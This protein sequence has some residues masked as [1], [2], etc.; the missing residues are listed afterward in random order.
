MSATPENHTASSASPIRGYGRARSALE[1][2][3]NLAC[4][5]QQR[6]YQASQYPESPHYQPLS[7]ETTP[8][9]TASLALSTRSNGPTALPITRL[10]SS[11]DRNASPTVGRRSSISSGL[12][13]HSMEPSQ[14]MSSLHNYRTDQLVDRYIADSPKIGSPVPATRSVTSDALPP[15]RP[16]PEQSQVPTP[17]DV[18][19]ESVKIGSAA[20]SEARENR[21]NI[22]SL[23]ERTFSQMAQQLLMA[24]LPALGWR[25]I[26]SLRLTSRALKSVIDTDGREL[27]LERFLGPQGYRIY[28][29]VQSQVRSLVPDDEIVTLDLRDLGAFRASQVVPLEQYSRFAKACGAGRLST[30]DLRLA[31]ATTRAWNRV[32]LRLRAQSLLPPASF[33]VPSFPDFVSDDQPVYKP[34]RAPQLRVWVPTNRGESWMTDGELIECEREIWRSGKGVWSQLRKGDIVTNIAI[35][36]FGNLGRMIYD[37]KFLRDLSFEWDVVG[38]LPNWLN[39]LAFSPS[40]FHGI[41][42]S[43]SSNPVFYLCLAPFVQQLQQTLRLESEKVSLASPQGHYQVKRHV[44]RGNIELSGGRILETAGGTTG[45]YEV[46][47]PDWDGTLHLETE[48]TTEHASLLI[49][50]TASNMPTP[51]HIVREKSRLGHLWIRPVAQK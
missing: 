8:P 42:A 17:V 41:L 40:H 39:M 26:V 29:P 32:V 22:Q 3:L 9:R 21:A 33:S 23:F 45:G 5:A 14:P 12:V 43:S 25:D 38:H 51:W 18:S 34:P 1:E 16:V 2:R 48:G 44:Y 50:R 28:T 31:R 11:I 47:H 13:Q 30:R 27:I 7:T 37:G 6:P 49:A 15:Q 19:L 46:V 10:P 35:E 36:A 20:R 24:I 4:E